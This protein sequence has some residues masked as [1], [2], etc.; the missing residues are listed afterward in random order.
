MP[1]RVSQDELGSRQACESLAGQ[2]LKQGR[3]VVIDRCNFDV[4][5]REHWIKI[6][7][8]YSSRRKQ[9]V[10]ARDR[11]AHRV[12]GS[13]SKCNGKIRVVAVFVNT[14]LEECKQRVM[15]RREH[16]TL[17]PT[18]ESVQVV[19]RFRRLLKPP[20]KSEGF[21]VV[22][23]AKTRDFG[24]VVQR[25]ASMLTP[26]CL[27]PPP[28]LNQSTGHT[29]PAANG[30]NSS[31][32]PEVQ[33]EVG[34]D[35]DGSET[36]TP[37][38]RAL[39]ILGSK[40]KAHKQPGLPQPAAVQIDIEETNAEA[41]AEANAEGEFRVDPT[42]G[43]SYCQ[44]DF[45]AEYGGLAEWQAAGEAQA[46]TAAAA[47]S[48]SV[49]AARLQHMMSSGLVRSTQTSAAAG[50]VQSVGKGAEQKEHES[51]K[52]EEERRVDASN[53]LA[54]T[55]AEFIEEY[56]MQYGA[57]EW[58]AA[59]HYSCG[60]EEDAVRE[61]AAVVVKSDPEE[62]LPLP[63]AEST[64]DDSM[65]QVLQEMGFAR[66]LAR[67]AL[68]SHKSLDAAAAWLLTQQESTTLEPEPEP[69]PYL[70]LPLMPPQPDQHRQSTAAFQDDI[71]E[72]VALQLWVAEGLCALG[73]AELADDLSEYFALALTETDGTEDGAANDAS[74]H[75]ELVEL[76]VDYG[77]E[78]TAAREFLC[79]APCQCNLRP[80]RTMR[81]QQ[82]ADTAAME[83]DGHGIATG[84]P[85][86][87]RVGMSVWQ[88][89]HKT[90]VSAVSW[91]DTK[92]LPWAD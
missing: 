19:E 74:Q 16:P 64:K 67:S 36:M 45:E 22:M 7:Q 11:F 73:L 42:D 69:E 18:R 24:I 77:C 35:S 5:Q 82:Q 85:I 51:Q 78:A 40:V 66:E 79:S 92:Q 59:Q 27:V 17:P 84:Q 80:H 62:H 12:G 58:A 4:S 47:E 71:L 53:G 57:V 48:E 3:S 89:Q 34:A 28:S 33:P 23:E 52:L 32:N 75:T 25:L 55:E 9:Q 91:V 49:R 46:A 38:K 6:A 21:D 29:S 13:D 20:R 39:Q 76:L 83:G 31:G 72:G 1:V 87:R 26:T 65:L 41:N 10:Q 14:P 70:G 86:T 81:Q 37:K 63:T 68:R 43:L 30:D 60:G 2:T 88:Q 50:M 61:A 15:R 44:A 90:R 54:Y 8:R 56:G